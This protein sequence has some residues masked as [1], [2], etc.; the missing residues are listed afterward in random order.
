MAEYEISNPSTRTLSL[1]SG[2]SVIYDKTGSLAPGGMGK[3]D[4]LYIYQTELMTDG[5]TRALAGDQWLHVT[6]LDGAAVDGWMAV[7]H[8]GESEASISAL[9]P[10][11]LSVTFGVDLEGYNPITLTGTLTPK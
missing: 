5:Q 11:D 6:E 10:K 9:P 3:G 4:F 7:M 1:R 2:P 8:L